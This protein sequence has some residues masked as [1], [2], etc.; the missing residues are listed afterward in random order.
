M[1]VLIQFDFSSFVYNACVIPLLTVHYS[2]SAQINGREKKTNEQMSTIWQ[3]MC[4]CVCVIATWEKQYEFVLW[5]YFQSQKVIIA[6]PLVDMNQN[7]HCVCAYVDMRLCSSTL[8]SLIFF[9]IVVFREF[10]SVSEIILFYAQSFQMR[11]C[12]RACFEKVCTKQA[13]DE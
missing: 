7:H 2:G 5:L 11:A 8:I 3:R 12:V 9:F 4:E 1:C 13:F 10:R 6:R